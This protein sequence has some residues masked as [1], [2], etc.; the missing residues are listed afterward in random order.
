MKSKMLWL[1]ASIVVICMAITFAVISPQQTLLTQCLDQILD[2]NVCVYMGTIQRDC[3]IP[4]GGYWR[5]AYCQTVERYVYY[6]Q[7][8][9]PP[10]VFLRSVVIV[11]LHMKPALQCQYFVVL[12]SIDS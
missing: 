9:Q 12:H 4:F 10:S 11:P 8:P 2:Y 5:R 6:R 3:C 1:V 7:P